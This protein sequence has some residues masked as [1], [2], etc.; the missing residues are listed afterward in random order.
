MK[1]HVLP[2]QM[3]AE[4]KGQ[5]NGQ[6]N[7][8]LLRKL[9]GTK[10]A[11]YRQAATAFNCLQMEAYFAGIDLQSTS[12]VDTYRSYERQLATFNDRYSEKLTGRVPPVSRTFGGKR[13]WLKRG[14]APSAAP[15]TSNHGWGLAIDIAGASGV[16]LAWM[17]GSSA[18]TSPVLKYGFSWEVESGKNAESWHIRY[19]CGDKPT[20]ATLDTL[21]VFPELEAK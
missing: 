10:G 13:Y 6:I 14:K 16:R 20:Q 15:G 2:L 1:F 3:P 19:V 17:L 8:N 9:H 5:E 4:L 21:K 11:L 7:S 12:T 18:W